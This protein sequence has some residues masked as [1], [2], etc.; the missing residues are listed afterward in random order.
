MT[1]TRLCALCALLASSCEFDPDDRCDPGQRADNELCVCLEG[2]V[3]ADVGC[4]PCGDNSSEED[5]VCKCDEGYARPDPDGPCEEAAADQGASCD[6]EADDPGCSDGFPH[7]Q[8]SD[9]DTGYCT[10]TACESDGDC[11]GSY[12]CDARESPSVCARPPIGMG[13]ACESDS[14]CEGKEATYCVTVMS[15]GCAV[16]GC[17]PPDEGCPPGSVCC[18]LESIGLTQLCVPEDLCP[19]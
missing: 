19:I 10:S 13:D 8:P 14:D 1:T 16:S 7:C 18:D 5:G 12:L 15:G 3:P 2:M 11:E 9:F 4:E 17:S 6:P